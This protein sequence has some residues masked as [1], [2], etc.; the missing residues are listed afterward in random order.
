MGVRELPV[1]AACAVVLRWFLR[2]P[3]A[4]GRSSASCI[5]AEHGPRLCMHGA[6]V[7]YGKMSREARRDRERA[8]ESGLQLTT[9]RRVRHTFR[10]KSSPNKARAAR[11]GGEICG[12][13]LRIEPFRRRSDHQQMRC[14]STRLFSSFHEISQANKRSIFF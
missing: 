11:G 9:N 6:G 5:L 2:E 13:R 1:P 12:E 8:S 4:R 3:R 7:G 14:C 10:A